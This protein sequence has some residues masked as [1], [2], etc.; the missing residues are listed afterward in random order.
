M[1]PAALVEQE[2][3]EQELTLLIREARRRQRRR[4]ISRAL[5]ALGITAAAALAA[6]AA[7]GAYSSTAQPATTGVSATRTGGA[8]PTSPAR[9]VANS[10]FAASVLG[11]GGLRLAIGN[12]YL[13]R[14]RRVVLGSTGTPGWSAMEVIWVR[15]PGHPGTI[16]VH[17]VRL[18]KSGP[19]D[20]GSSDAGQSPG[21]PGLSL[22]PGSANTAPGGVQLYPGVIWVRSGGCYALT[23]N[24][25]GLR[26]R[27]VFDAQAR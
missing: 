15:Q 19:I 2:S 24:G 25:R 22:V 11:R 5:V 16:A 1:T 12:R 23:V 18:G 21:S 9:F 3:V 27:I 26:E 17:G 20:V 8:C 7:A 14:S 6:L 13:K 4:R 10:S